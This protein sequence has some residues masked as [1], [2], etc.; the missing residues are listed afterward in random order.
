MKMKNSTKKIICK[1]VLRK[2]F[3]KTVVISE[4]LW[5][6]IVCMCINAHI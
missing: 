1:E 3:K 4:S 6:T 5:Y 2:F